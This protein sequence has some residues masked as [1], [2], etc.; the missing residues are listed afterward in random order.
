MTALR[1]AVATS[2]ELAARAAGEVAETGGNAVD[3]AIAAALIAMNTEPGVCSLAGG[4]YLTIARPGDAAVTID[5]GIAVPGKLLDRPTNQGERVTMDYG[6]GVDTVVGPA[7]VGVPGTVAALDAAWQ[8]YGQARWID[9]WQPVIRAADAGFPLP[10]ACHYYL[11]YSGRSIFSR[12]A[13]G[14]AALFDGDGRLRP[15]GAAIRV[16]HLAESLEELATVGADSFYRGRIG[17]AM[18]DHVADG[19]GALTTEDLASYQ[20]VRRPALAFDLREWRVACNPPPAIGGA[21]LASLMTLAA[22]KLGAASSDATQVASTFAA[23]QIATLGYRRERLDW[24]E[25]VTADV[26]DLL[27]LSESGELLHRGMSSATVHTSAVDDQG[28]ACSITSSAGYGAGD[29]PA[30]TGLWLNNCLGELELNRR[31]LAAGPPGARLPSNMCP[32]V[33]SNGDSVVAFGSP[34][35]DRITTALQQVLLRHLLLD[36]DLTTAIASPRLHYEVGHNRIAVE[37]GLDATSLGLSVEDYPA[38]SMYFGGVGAARFDVT[39]L[40]AA[41]DPRRAGGVF[42]SARA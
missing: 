11:N 37:H 29:M 36:T 27:R 3:C 38:N 22:P 20:A 23:A 35:A 42:I 10:Q 15:A 24:S 34:G 31:G 14:E 18:V 19:G 12:S 40:S 7:S 28:L 6:G 17:Q 21:V 39:G 25:D 41:A 1:V 16:P 30:E 9:L 8:Q 26:E 33:A 5:G 2:S 32:G 13:D 4:A